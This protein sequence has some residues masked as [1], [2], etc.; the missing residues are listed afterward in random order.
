MS[1]F[2]VPTITVTTLTSWLAAGQTFTMLDVRPAE[3]RRVWA[4][5][6][7]IHLDASA[8]L[9]AS[10]PLVLD[11]LS[12]PLDQPIVVICATGKTSVLAAE[13]LLSQGYN[14]LALEGG[15][16]AWSL[17]W[18][19][20]AL[21]VPASASW[22]I[23]LRRLGKGCLSYIVESKGRAAVIDASLPSQVYCDLA[24][25]YGWRITHVFDTHIH[26][27]HLS[28]SRQLAALTGARLILPAQ[29]R[30]RFSAQMVKDGDQVTVGGATIRVLATPGH[31]S[32]SVSY[33]LDDRALFTGDTL[34]LSGV[35][36]PDLTHDGEGARRQAS[37]LYES[38]LR[39]FT[40]PEQT[41]VLPSH[42]NDPIR[43]DAKP[44]TGTLGEL[45]QQLHDLRLPEPAFAA[46]VLARLPLPPSNYQTIIGLNELGDCPEHASGSI[47]AGSNQ[48]AALAG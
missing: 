44:V 30:V 42:T 14:A 17:A 11:S 16:Q 31:T 21:P 35:G 25:L 28:R 12:L 29:Q 26:A 19:Y 13:Y 3:Q 9:W 8:A 34:S 45:R 39:L 1:T 32:E 23:Q 41:L 2:H 15:M 18:N 40:L 22:I 43:F 37:L 33:L 6:G 47:E 38:L 7:S 27:D 20:V 36:R 4:I 48:W 5:P 46:R 24:E 10:E